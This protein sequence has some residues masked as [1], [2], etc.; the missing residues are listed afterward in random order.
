MWAVIMALM[1][2]SNVGNLGISAI[3]IKFS[4]ETFQEKDIR[5]RINQVMTGGYAIVFLMSL[6]TFLI[7]LATRKLIAGSLDASTTLREQFQQ[8]LFWIALGVFPQFLA[9]VPHGYLLSQLRNWAVRQAEFFSMALLWLGAIVIAGINKNLVWIGIWCF[10][11]HLLVLGI[12]IGIV[13]RLHPF[14]FQLDIPTL[15]KMSNFSGYMFLESIA[16]VAF[17]QLDRVVVGFTLGPVIAGAYSVGTSLALR[18]TMVTGLATEVMVPYA[19]LRDSL[20]DHE[21]LQDVFRRLSRYVGWVLAGMG[22]F[23]L[24]WMHELL[25]L[26]ISPEYAARYTDAFRLL[27]VAYGLLSLCRPAHQMLTG[28]GKVKITSSIYMLSSLLM[29]GGVFFLSKKIGLMGAVQ[30]NLVLV[31]LL[32]FNLVAYHL[33]NNRPIWQNMFI[34]LKWGL[35]I[36]P[37]VY[38]MIRL[39]PTETIGYKLIGTILLGLFFLLTSARDAYL[40]DIFRRI[41]GLFFGKNDKPVP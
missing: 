26:W 15:R 19:S 34:D 6:T 29:L 41:A 5:Q 32:V 30:A 21:K 23:L 10:A 13:Q 28:M 24:I 20:K 3:V 31:L 38:G 18:L 12:Y 17:Q 8:A 1:F 14:R 25:A 4:S 11:S 2:F 7:L 39:L 27:V 35:I 16:V 36:P 40:K 37:F 22:S 33:L 9:R